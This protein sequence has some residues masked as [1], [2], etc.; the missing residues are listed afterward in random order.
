MAISD[1][2][3]LLRGEPFQTHRSSGVQLVR[4]DTHNRTEAAVRMGR[5]PD[6]VKKLYGRAL[7]RLEGMRAEGAPFNHRFETIGGVLANEAGELMLEFFRERRIT[8]PVEEIGSEDITER[9][10]SG[11]NG[12]ASKAVR[13]REVPRGFESHPLRH[14]SSELA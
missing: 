14:P 8:G 6:A 11:H 10:R 5:T 4:A 1:D 3:E 2:D 7:A 13:G 12:A 9:Y